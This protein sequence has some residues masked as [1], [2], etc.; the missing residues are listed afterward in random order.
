LVSA[1]PF[2]FVI[3][4]LMM[5]LLFILLLWSSMWFKKNT[6]GITIVK[7][8][9]VL[10][11]MWIKKNHSQTHKWEISFCFVTYVN[12]RK[13]TCEPTS[14]HVIYFLI[15][16]ESKKPIVGFQMCKILSILLMRELKKPFANL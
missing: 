4:F 6:Y 8:F 2:A 14:V 3:D 12:W 11:P 9:Y 13:T 15:L 7:Y 10:S 1:F 5:L 16:H